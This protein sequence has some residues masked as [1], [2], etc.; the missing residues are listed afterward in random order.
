MIPEFSEQPFE[1]RFAAMGDEAEGKFMEVHPKGW[2]V[3]GL[4][5]PP[6]RVGA[7]PAKIRYAPD[8]IT[9]DGFVE[10][11]G[12]GHKQV[13]KL[14]IEKHVALLQWDQEMPT[15]LFVWDSKNKRYAYMGMQALTDALIHAKPGRFPEG[16]ATWELPVGKLGATWTTT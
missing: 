1:A 8:F 10:T 2:A 11:M 13:L 14:K 9:S 15:Q 3:W 4:R 5:R 12:V 16:K 7:L 6:I